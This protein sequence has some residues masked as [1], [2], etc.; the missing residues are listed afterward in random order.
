MTKV[1]IKIF[2]EFQAVKSYYPNW[3]TFS[4]M[5]RKLQ[6]FL[7][8]VVFLAITSI[9]FS[10]PNISILWEKEIA[11][12]GR[13]IKP[14][15]IKVAEDKNIVRV[16]G[17]SY[18]YRAKENLRLLDLFEYRVNLKDNTS[19]LKNLMAMDGED[20][21][22]NLPQAGVK[23]SRLID[24]NIVMI[25]SQYKSFNFQE[26]TVGS[27]WQVK[28][29]EI[30]GLTRRS[31]STH[32]ACRNINGD[33]FL[34]GN[35][36]YIRKVKSDGTVAWDTNYKSD[37]G[38][39]GTLGV[40]F[41]ESENMLVAFGFSFEPD[42]KFTSK[43]SSLW[44]ANLDSKG[45]FKAK[46]EFEGIVNLGKSPSFCLSKSGNPIVI[47]DNNAELWSYKIYVS[48]FS[49]DLNTKAWTTPLFDGK[50][51][52]IQMSLTPFE[53]DYTLAT[54]STVSTLEGFGC[55]LHF[56]ILDKNG[57]IINQAI[58]EDLEGYDDLVAVLKDRIFLV[59][60]RS[61]QEKDKNTEFARLICFKINPFKM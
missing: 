40:A 3:K 15:T 25:R 29:R 49:K 2:S 44:L 1:D 5:I 28:T 9:A 4:F 48:K 47:Y 6:I 32:G 7:I 11:Q 14:Y 16:V 57:G 36:G 23:D 12:V 58:F 27:D 19:E 51:M 45:N 42:T 56:Y 38:E 37:K 10:E 39:D 61:K 31:I 17:V 26:L 50:D 8:A 55:N 46:T 43:D 34:C 53:D 22:F 35:S 41:S 52:M 54:L 13:T 20:I 60:N 24:N 30:P 33:A 59:T 21:T 18:I